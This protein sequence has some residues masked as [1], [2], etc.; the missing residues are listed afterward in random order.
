MIDMENAFGLLVGSMIGIGIE[1]VKGPLLDMLEP[2]IGKRGSL[3]LQAGI[4]S[5]IATTASILNVNERD[6]LMKGVERGLAAS[7]TV[8]AAYYVT[9]LR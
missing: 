1:L 6:P 7:H 2:Y 3:L 8:I 5:A 4:S 9:E